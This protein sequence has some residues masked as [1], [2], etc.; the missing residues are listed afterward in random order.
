MQRKPTYMNCNVKTL[1][2]LC[3]FF[4]FCIIQRNRELWTTNQLAEVTTYL[5]TILG[6][7]GIMLY[8]LSAFTQ[9]R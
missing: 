2:S 8:R 4:T 1:F 6:D 7:E 9:R 5:K 3:A